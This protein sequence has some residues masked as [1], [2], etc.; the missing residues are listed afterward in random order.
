MICLTSPVE[1]ASS[2]VRQPYPVHSPPGSPHP[3]HIISYQSL[4]SL[5]SSVT[6]RPFTPDLNSTQVYLKAVAERLK[7]Y[8][9]V[10]LE[11][12]SIPFLHSSFLF[13]L[14]CLHT[15]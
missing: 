13:H 3:A 9:A 5:L 11:N 4:S 15:F 8:N 1:S 14:D 2:S 12:P 10:Q 6:P 7:R